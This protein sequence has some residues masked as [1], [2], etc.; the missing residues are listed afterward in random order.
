[1]FSSK[2]ASL[3]LSSEQA[4]LS[5]FLTLNKLVLCLTMNKLV[6]VLKTRNIYHIDL[7]LILLGF[8]SEQASCYVAV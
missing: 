8:N 3:M 7:L 6:S 4:S 1:M 2:Q 5:F